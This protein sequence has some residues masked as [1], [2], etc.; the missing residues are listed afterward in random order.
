MDEPL[1]AIRWMMWHFGSGDALWTGWALLGVSLTLSLYRVRLGRVISAGA[2]GL[3][4]LSLSAW[5]SIIMTGC[6]LGSSVVWMSLTIRESWAVASKNP[7]R[8]P[9]AQPDA[10]LRD[11]QQPE[12]QHHQRSRG[13]LPG[14]A[15]FWRAVTGVLL[16]IAIPLELVWYRSP[17]QLFSDQTS[18]AV[19]GDSISAGLNEREKTWPI[20]LAE[21]TGNPI[22]DASQPGATVLSAVQQLERLDGRGAVLWIEIGGNDILESLPSDVYGERLEGLLIQARQRYRH[23]I[24]MEIPAPPFGNAYGQIQRRLARQY[25]I[26]LVPKRCL[27][28]ILTTTGGTQDGIHLSDA[29]QTSLSRLVAHTLGWPITSVASQYIRVDR[30][31]DRTTSFE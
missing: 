3:I 26:P 13:W 22:Y 10:V 14:N 2:L 15:S 16:L 30:Q 9:P 31:T 20:Q 29:G 21:S 17:T 6:V 1:A 28:Q 18:L 24:L 25:R 11:D 12:S 23:I 7:L 27:L 5:P 8:L 4:W 19:I